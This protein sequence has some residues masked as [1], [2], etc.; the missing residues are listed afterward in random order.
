M[1]KPNMHS[2]LQMQQMLQLGLLLRPVNLTNVVPIWHG[3]L[4]QMKHTELVYLISFQ[5]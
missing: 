4:S 3:A 1:R 2:E 5:K